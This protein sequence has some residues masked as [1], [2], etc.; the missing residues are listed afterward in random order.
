MSGLGGPAVP[1]GFQVVGGE[2]DGATVLTEPHVTT[3]VDDVDLLFMLRD[4]KV[5]LL[6][7]GMECARC[8]VQRIAALVWQHIEAR[9]WQ[10]PCECSR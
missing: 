10:D 3:V 9:G 2:L 4:G 5:S 8:A 1:G 7:P 6:A